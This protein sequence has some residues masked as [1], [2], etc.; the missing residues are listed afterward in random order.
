MM[1]KFVYLLIT[2]YFLLVACAAP[3]PTLK[4]ALVAPFEGRQRQVGYDAFPSIRMALR[5][6]N[7]AGGIA[8]RY[9]IEFVAYNDNAD[10]AFAAR[11]AHNVAQDES[12]LVVLGHLR[13]NTTDAALPVYAQAGLPVLALDDAPIKLQH[14]H[15]G[16]SWPHQLK[17][18]ATSRWRASHATLHRGLGRAATWRRLHPRLYCYKACGAGHCARCN[19]ARHTQPRGRGAS[20]R[21]FVGVQAIIQTITALQHYSITA[22]NSLNTMAVA[23]HTW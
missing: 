20:V 13:Q 16:L 6:A 17:P 23:P 22:S 11:V 2:T 7:A 3:H 10:P 19:C 9:L 18:P 1:R 14:Q 15:V 5:E 8:N 21:C 4:I 12:V